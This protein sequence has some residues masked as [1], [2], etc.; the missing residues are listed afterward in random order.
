MWLIDTNVVIHAIR[1][2]PP[3]VRARL[4]EIGPSAVRVSSISIAELWY[5]ALR[6]PQPKRR[7][8]LYEAFL[9]P[10]ET[11][12]FDRAAAVQHAELRHA[13]RH[14]PIGERDLLIASIAVSAGLIVVTSNR[15]EFERIPGLV[16][17][18]WTS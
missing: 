4:S 8:A 15:R 3:S 17:E 6:T 9:S 1:N 10:I 2:D 5:G 13:L 7:R 16:V 11:L 14:A 12:A 18:D